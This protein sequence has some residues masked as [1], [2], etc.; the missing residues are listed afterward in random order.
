MT[1]PERISVTY[2]NYW[3]WYIVHI[4]DA[5]RNCRIVIHINKTPLIDLHG[6][7]TYRSSNA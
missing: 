4:T 6:K 5:D 7:Q 3:E 2:C 1:I